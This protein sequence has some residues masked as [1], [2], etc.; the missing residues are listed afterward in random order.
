MYSHMIQGRF[1]LP[2]TSATGRSILGGEPGYPRLLVLVGKTSAVELS[3]EALF[4]AIRAHKI[5]LS[6]GPFIDF[7]SPAWRRAG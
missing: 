4:K 7:R 2:S 6:S 1:Y 5:E 3:E